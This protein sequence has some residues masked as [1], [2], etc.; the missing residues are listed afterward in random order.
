MSKVALLTFVNEVVLSYLDH[1]YGYGYF[2][3]VTFVFPPCTPNS[4]FTD[5]QREQ[6]NLFVILGILGLL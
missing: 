6:S 2:I 4:F 3:L 1:L 5:F